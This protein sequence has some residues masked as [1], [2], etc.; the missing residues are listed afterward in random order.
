MGYTGLSMANMDRPQDEPCL[1]RGVPTFRMTRVMLLCASG[2]PMV[3]LTPTALWAQS[4]PKAAVGASNQGEIVV[5]AQRRKQDIQAVPYNITAVSSES[6]TTAGATSANDLSRVVAGLGGVNEGGVSRGNQNQF[7]LRG[8]RTEG[9]TS[10]LRA[11]PNVASVS[12]YFGDTPV[13]FPLLMKDL[14][15]V[16][17]LR[18]PQGTLYGSGAQGGAIRFIPNRPSFDKINGQVNASTGITEHAGALNASAD[19][20]INLPLSDNLAIRLSGAYE[21]TAGFIDG[22]D[23]LVLDANGVPVPRV[24][25]N[26][27]SGSLVGPVDTNTNN[28]EQ[29]M[30]RAALRYAPTEWLDMELAYLRQRASA[31]DAQQTNPYYLGGTEDFSGGLYPD[32]GFTTRPGGKYA[33]TSFVRRP[34]DNKLDLYSAT[35]TIDFGFASLTSATSYYDAHSTAVDDITSGYV[36]PNFNILPLYYLGYPRFT[37]PTKADTKQKGFIQEVRL[38]SSDISPFSYVLGAY[39][40]KLRYKTDLLQKSPGIYDFANFLGTQ[41]LNPQLRDLLF[42]ERHDD[43]TSDKAVFGELTFRPRPAWQI[44]GGFRFFK[45]SFS[46]DFVQTLPWSGFGDGVSEPVSEGTTRAS[47]GQKVSSHVFKLNTSYD[48]NQDTK[49]YATYSRGFRRGGSNGLPTTGPFASLP[50]Y[51]LYQPD[52]ADNYEVGIKGRAIGRRLRYSLSAYWIDLKDFQFNSF[53]PSFLR[54]TFNGGQARSKGL[55]LETQYRAT[56]RLE[57]TLSYTFTDAKVVKGAAIYDLP[58][59]AAFTGA[60]PVLAISIPEGASLPGVSRHAINGAADYKLPLNGDSSLLLHADASYR[61]AQNSTL[62]ATTSNFF[63]IPEMF[64]G[65]VRMVYD[66]GKSWTLS[67]FVNNVNNEIGYTGGTGGN[68]VSRIFYSRIVGRP[69]TYGVATG[70]HF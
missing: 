14:E 12:T 35:A 60:P 1:A 27:A 58:G 57:L 15:R 48:F 34:V 28:T 69:R 13:F 65:N 24:P 21:R 54:V 68:N 18:G 53:T 2:L 8:L 4:E 67:A 45:D 31:D 64:I 52:F 42:T 7:S 22:V 33:S 23:Q 37:A 10:P 5:T 55:E 17:V 36:T 20:A 25:G 38:V 16:E 41:G 46:T 70:W 11:T 49:L 26:P 44:T 43:K 47:S 56:D 63:R 3:A 50:Q 66:S 30:A 59:L 19:G 6:L 62:D 39:Y 9:A 32:G 51:I 40:E 61:S 29:W